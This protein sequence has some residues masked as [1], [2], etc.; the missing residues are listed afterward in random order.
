MTNPIRPDLV[1]FFTVIGQQF[2]L[3]Q[4]TNVVPNRIPCKCFWENIKINI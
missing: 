1:G 4:Y 2:E 3:F